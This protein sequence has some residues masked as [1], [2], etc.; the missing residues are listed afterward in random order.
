[1]VH[2][3]GHYLL[4]LGQSVVRQRP[5]RGLLVLS[6]DGL[7]GHLGEVVL[8]LGGVCEGTDRRVHCLGH[9]ERAAKLFL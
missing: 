4:L 6:L 1:M 7:G 8:V 5:R 9:Y 3:K 2:N